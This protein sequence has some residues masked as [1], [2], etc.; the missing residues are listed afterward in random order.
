[1]SD[2]A[3]AGPADRGIAPH[4]RK[5]TAMR[6]TSFV[7]STL[8]AIVVIGGAT[9]SADRLKL[10]SG[11]TVSGSFMSADVKNVR[12]LLD[13]GR[14]AEFKIEDITGVEFS[15]RKAPPAAAATP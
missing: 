4:R 6:T 15:P 13:N 3:A 1:A 7:F 11:Q 14:V 10:R 2:P 8:A 9:L 12:M 5:V